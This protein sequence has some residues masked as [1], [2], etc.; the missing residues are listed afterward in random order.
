MAEFTL[1]G[2]P[3]HTSGDLPSIGSMAPHFT[4]VNADLVDKS[5]KDFPG[6]RKMLS[7]VPSL[8]TPICSLSAIK[9]NQS[10]EEHNDVLAF[11]ISADLPFAQKR[12]CGVENLH[13]IQTLSM[14]R[15]KDFAKSYGLL[16][17]DGPLAGLSARAIIILDEQN[18]V[19]YVEFV[20]EITHE[21]NYDRALQA[22]LK[23]P[24]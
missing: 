9:F 3:F 14:M 19:V 15:S 17:V 22:L 10:L 11:F 13:N 1:K 12:F 6:K 16:I 5:L 2:T 21:P 23:K 8:D 24:S 4:L 18:K 7:I 20:S